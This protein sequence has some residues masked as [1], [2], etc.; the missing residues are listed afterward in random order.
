M[1]EFLAGKALLLVLD[2]CEHLL[3]AV[4]ALV[5]E[6]VLGCPGVRVLATSREGLN[7][8]GERMLGVA[9]LDVP[10]DAAGTEGIAEC[11]AVVLFVE[12][13]RAVKATL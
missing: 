10:G 3:R 13:A 4:A 1:I 12:R 11:D 6:V 5:D 7:V 2:N 8:A 9:S